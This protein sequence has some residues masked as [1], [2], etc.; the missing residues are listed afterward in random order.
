MTQPVEQLGAAGVERRFCRGFLFVAVENALSC[1]T[2]IRV[3]F[4]QRFEDGPVSN[5]HLRFDPR[6]V[7]QRPR[8]RAVH[9]EEDRTG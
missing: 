4:G 3:Q 5:A 6:E 8:Q 2:A 9:V 1:R 7:Q